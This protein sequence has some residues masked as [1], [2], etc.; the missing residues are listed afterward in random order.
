MHKTL[1]LESG[2]ETDGNR[3][4]LGVL[5]ILVWI[6]AVQSQFL[7]HQIY[8]LAYFQCVVYMERT[9]EIGIR[10]FIAFNIFCMH[11]L[12]QIYTHRCKILLMRPGS[13]RSEKSKNCMGR[14]FRQWE[15]HTWHFWLCNLTHLKAIK[16]RRNFIITIVTSKDFVFYST[17]GAP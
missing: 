8:F 12:L 15:N 3:F 9:L 10:P 6:G 5:L 17:L 11:M 1:F 2:V 7:A 14:G 13:T 4:Q 16:S